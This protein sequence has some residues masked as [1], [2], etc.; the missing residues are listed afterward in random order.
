MI[1]CN[2]TDCESSNRSLSE[3]C[4]NGV[5]ISIIE[6]QLMNLGDCNCLKRSIEIKSSICI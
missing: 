6:Q 3:I 5:K 1:F 2:I 4:M